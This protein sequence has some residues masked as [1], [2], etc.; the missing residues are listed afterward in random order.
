MTTEPVEGLVFRLAV[1]SIAIMLISALYNMTDTYFVSSLGT[2]PVA[3][4]G[5]AFPLMVIIMAIGF[6]FGQ[7]AGNYISRALGAQKTEDASRMAATGF[8]S[9]FFAMAIIAVFGLLFLGPLVGLLGATPTIEPYAKEYIFYI[10]LASPV[11]VASTVLN[12]LLRFQ[13]SAA[14]AM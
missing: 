14:L 8:I 3:A 5:I 11:I 6:F 10:L 13:G 2:S 7:G 12:P 1:P 9:G 4:V